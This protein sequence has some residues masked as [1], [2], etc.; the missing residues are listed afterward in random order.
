MANRALTPKLNFPKSLWERRE[1]WW[2][3]TKREITGRY[4]GSQLGL[5]WSILNPILMLAVYTFV[6]S[7]IFKARWGTAEGH[8]PWGF[9]VN[10]FAGLIV[11]NLFAECAS[12]APTLILNNPNYVKKVVFPLEILSA[13][14]VG[15]A[16]FHAMTSLT[17]LLVF[18]VIVFGR[19]PNTAY[20]L[21]LVWAPL[22]L[23]SLAVS[24]ILA[25]LGVF[26]RDI[27]QIIGVLVSMLMFLSPVFFPIS[28]VP[29]GL[30]WALKI[31]PLA[32]VIE[33]TRKVLIVG[34]SPQPLEIITGIVTGCIACELSYRGF[35]KIKSS[36]A[37]VI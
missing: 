9:A 7:Q 20:W 25:A 32:G 2:Q 16:L 19:I 28:A 3:L 37:D 34:G 30:Q 26:L 21:P 5:G 35:Q 15:S 36:F 29:E 13:V 23:A 14:S 4:R 22:I 12:R 11:F 31:N 17:V 6:F 8:G 33:Q 24:W 27:G 1:L 10:L 18:E